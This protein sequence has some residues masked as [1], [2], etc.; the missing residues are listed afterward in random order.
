LKFRI[1]D[2]NEE[3]ANSYIKLITEML[4]KGFLSKYRT[5]GRLIISILLQKITNP[6]LT[7][8]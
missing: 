2:S 6:N 3:I 8:I 5:P 7:N 4:A 1:Q